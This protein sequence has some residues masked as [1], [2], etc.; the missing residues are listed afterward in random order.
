MLYKNKIIYKNKI[1]LYKNKIVVRLFVFFY[2]KLLVYLWWV[3][4]TLQFSVL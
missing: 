4:N 1:V 2:T 3:Y